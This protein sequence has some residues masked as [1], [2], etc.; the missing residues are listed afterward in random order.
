[1]CLADLE[2]K[3]CRVCV[4]IFPIRWLQRVPSRVGTSFFIFGGFNCDSTKAKGRHQSY[5]VTL[6][7]V[8]TLSILWVMETSPAEACRGLYYLFASSICLIVSDTLECRLN[9]SIIAIE[10]LV[11]V[12]TFTFFLSQMQGTYFKTNHPVK[13]MVQ[14]TTHSL[15]F[16]I[17]HV[18]SYYNACFPS[19]LRGE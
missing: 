8:V 17:M 12:E 7:V 18:M 10:Y 14:K 13:I 9:Y 19:I 4:F 2:R 15:G 16:M 6:L 11:L 3:Q 1:M 5:C